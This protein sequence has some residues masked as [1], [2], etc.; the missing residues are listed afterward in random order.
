M[1]DVLCFKIPEKHWKSRFT[2]QNFNLNGKGE[3]G[4]RQHNSA[5]AGLTKLTRQIETIKEAVAG[6]G[7]E[8][9][10][11][12]SEEPLSR[13]SGKVSHQ[14]PLSHSAALLPKESV[15]PTADICSASRSNV[16]QDRAAWGKPHGFCETQRLALLALRFPHNW[17]SQRLS[18]HGGKEP[19]RL[20]SC[21]RPRA[22]ESHHGVAHTWIPQAKTFMVGGTTLPILQRT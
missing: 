11:S 22:P 1:L 13:L 20:S 16:R 12:S 5:A 3:N 10:S 15:N 7:A 14:L 17:R 18:G 6:C 4:N 8:P 21:S 19:L 2:Q 9:S